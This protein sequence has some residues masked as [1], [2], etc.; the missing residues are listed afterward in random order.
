MIFKIG[1]VIEVKLRIN[2]IFIIGTVAT[3]ISI[4]TGLTYPYSIKRDDGKTTSANAKE[5]MLL[6]VK[7][8]DLELALDSALGR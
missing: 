7:N 3:I 5:M 6:Y 2:D 1:D 4:K 8:P